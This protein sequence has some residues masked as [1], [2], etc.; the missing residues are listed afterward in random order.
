MRSIL[1]ELSERVR[2]AMSAVGAEG[3]PLVHVSGDER[4]GD[5]QS[6]C[7]MGLAK[8]LGKKPR[9]IAE[10]IV[11]VLDVSDMCEPPE[12]AGPGF[13]N[14]RLTPAFLGETLSALP[15]VSEP[16]GRRLGIPEVTP[17]RTVVI[18]LSAPNLAKEMHVGHLRST[19]IGDAAARILE[20][21]GH[22]VIRENHVGDWGTQFG[23][24]VAYLRRTQADV[25]RRLDDLVIADLEAFY[26]EAKALFD[27]DDGF[28]RESQETVVALQRGEPETRRVWKAFCDESLRHCHTIYDRLDVSLIDRGESFY[29]DLMPIVIQRLVDAGHAVESDGALVVY[30]PGYTTKS[31]DPLPL[32][33]RKSDGGYNY[34]SSDLA[35][36]VHRVDELGASRIVYVV[37]AP[38]KQHLAMVFATARLAGW[39][40][41]GVSLEHLAFGSMLGANGKPF[42]TREGGTVKLKSLLDEAVAKARE[43][44]EGASD[45]PRREL[46]ASQ[47][48]EVAETVGIAAIKYFDLSH[49]LT[50][51]YKFDV[52]TMLAMDGNTAPYMLYAYARIR[53][54]GR[55]AD[56]DFD[57]LPPHPIRVEHPT[58]LALAKM[59]CRFRDVVDQ[60]G[61]DIRPNLLTDYLY[62]LSKTFSRFYDRNVGVRV[63]D[64]EGDDVRESRLR[65]CDVTARTLKLGLSLLGIG[66]VEQM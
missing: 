61:H 14:F 32:I 12:I 24:L 5:Y 57:T 29:E 50:T 65:L 60:I 54:I 46:S 16:G 31:G 44:I 37:G 17:R 10:G 42:K 41:D 27:A 34:A 45:G 8:T 66:T 48:D 26:V 7:A 59:L 4:F 64:A 52:N 15:S 53:S 13:I 36:L 6:N 62:D 3:D 1:V 55:N 19:V 38:Q 39:V 2:V 35:T 20:F 49:A 30:L 51:D 58:E 28:K 25:L 47:V 18:D 11:A 21:Q 9:E 33:V 63:I 23:M 40:E 22:K 56:V 43:V